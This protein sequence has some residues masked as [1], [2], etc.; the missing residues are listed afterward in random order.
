MPQPSQGRYFISSFDAYA[1]LNVTLCEKDVCKF[2]CV[3]A[4]QRFTHLVGKNRSVEN[5][6]I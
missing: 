2:V 1:E 6:K 4:K 5:Q 3:F